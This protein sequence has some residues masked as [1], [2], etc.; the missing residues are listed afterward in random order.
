MLQWKRLTLLEKSFISNAG[1]IYFISDGAIWIKKLKN[2]YFPQAIGVLDIWHLE[3]EL[4][5]ALGEEKKETI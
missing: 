2:H 4:K 3:R 5:W 1:K